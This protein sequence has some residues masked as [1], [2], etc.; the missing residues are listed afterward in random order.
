MGIVTHPLLKAFF[1]AVIGANPFEPRKFI[2]IFQNN[3]LLTLTVGN[4][5]CMHQGAQQQPVRVHQN[6]AFA[7]LDFF[8]PASYPQS[9]PASVVLTLWLSSTPIDG[10]GSRSSAVRTISRK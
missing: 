10:V 9:P 1:V 7:P 4:V 3:P 8:F 6:L 5:R 2:G